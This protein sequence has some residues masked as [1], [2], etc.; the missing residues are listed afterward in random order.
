MLKTI[1]VYAVLVED[2]GERGAHRTA[3]S[4]FESI[5]PA[6]NSTQQQSSSKSSWV[7]N[8]ALLLALGTSIA[9]FLAKK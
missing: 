8:T 9:F 2:L 5:S 7:I 3:F 6:K 1:P 4:D